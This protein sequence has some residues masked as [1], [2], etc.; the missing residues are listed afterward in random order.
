MA[1]DE[2]LLELVAAGGTGPVLR[3][4]RWQ[5]PTLSLGYF[6]PYA[7]RH[8]HGPSRA[9]P[10]VRRSSGGGAIVHDRELTYSLVLPAAHPLASNVVS[11]CDAVHA[12]L[13]AAVRLQGVAAQLCRPTRTD[14]TANHPF[15]CF[16]RRTPGDVLVGDT[17]I[18]GSAQRR[19]QGAT[20]QHGS[21]LLDRSQAAPEL[22]GLAQLAKAPLDCQQLLECWT[23]QLEQRLGLHFEPRTFRAACTR[24]AGELTEKYRSAAWTQRR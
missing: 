6:Q 1:L 16:A 20:L 9:C 24:R 4:Y 5:Q 10:V 21:V 14:R 11:L 3:F 12:G 15:L 18:A 19:R 13:V 2:A 22:A 7:E 8:G 23:G 17:K